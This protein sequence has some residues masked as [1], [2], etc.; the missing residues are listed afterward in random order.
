MQRAQ[1]VLHVRY[2]ERLF[3][4][5]PPRLAFILLHPPIVHFSY[6]SSLF[7]HQAFIFT[8]TILCHSTHSN[9][10]PAIYFMSLFNTLHAIRIA[11]GRSLVSLV[12][13]F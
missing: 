12:I 1:L 7:S 3:S 11:R 9:Q 10:L 6:P 8:L 2:I 5:P 4:P 13:R